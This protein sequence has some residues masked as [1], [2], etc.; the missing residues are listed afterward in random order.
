MKYIFLIPLIIISSSIY[1]GIKFG[2]DSN[3]LK[4][5]KYLDLYK[6]LANK[7][8]LSHHE[9][10]GSYIFKYEL[11]VDNLT[12]TNIT[13]PEEVIVIQGNTSESYPLINVEF[14]NIPLD[15][16]MKFY[17][18]FGYFSESSEQLKIHTNLTSIKGE[19]YFLPNGSIQ[20]SKFNVELSDLSIDFQSKWINFLIGIFTNFITKQAEKY[21]N[22]KNQQITDFVNNWID[23]EFLYDIG[24][25]IGL[26]LTCIEKPILHRF[27]K[28]KI[29]NQ[30][31]YNVFFNKKRLNEK[32]ET[33]ILTFG[34][35]GSIYP[36]LHPE[37]K[38]LINDPINMTY[39]TQFYDN[40]IQILISDY[41]LNTLLFLAHQSGYLHMEFKNDLINII[42]W[43]F[44]V[45]GLKDILP[46]YSKLYPKNNYQVE[47]KGY[48][49]VNYYPQP[50]IKISKEITKLNLIFGL[51]FNTFT[52]DD[53]FDEPIKDVN[54]N[55]SSTI[56]VHF[57]V[58]KGNLNIV[59]QN[60]NINNVYTLIDNLKIN[61]TRFEKTIEDAMNNYVLPSFDKYIKNIEIVEILSKILGTKMRNFRIG[62]QDGYFVT[63]IG[64]NGV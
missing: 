21:I 27:T 2:I 56:D 43:N 50:I 22:S 4:G 59:I 35:H 32:I 18:K 20:I 55:I 31:L 58:Q 60:F 63:S 45:F 37:L 57:I 6:Y 3:I 36:N 41:T 64:V 38:P 49:S 52:S 44:S 42:P 28:E 14:K 33:T 39:L 51:D 34:L 17:V 1:S 10:S 48:V 16:Q 9:E 13:S 23:N 5:F 61:I 47:M 30:K 7:I 12:R 54:L 62:S 24:F 25:G 46:E 26:N 40:E 11:T 15:I 53:P 8:L 19:Y 29:F